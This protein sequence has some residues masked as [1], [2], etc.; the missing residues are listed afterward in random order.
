MSQASAHKARNSMWSRDP[1]TKTTQAEKTLT[2]NEKFLTYSTEW[3][4]AQGM[5]IESSGC[6]QILM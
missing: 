6:L 4:V 2:S 1:L 5:P 3:K